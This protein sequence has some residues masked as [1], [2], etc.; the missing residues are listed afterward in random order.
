MARILVVEDD[1]STQ[2]LISA[3]LEKDGHKVVLCADGHEALL[4]VDRERP[5]LLIS[6]INLPGMDGYALVRE[7]RMNPQWLHLPIIYLSSL[8]NRANIR[9][10]MSTG[11]DDYLTKPFSVRELRDA[12]Y[13]QLKK[14]E[15]LRGVQKTAIES[16]IERTKEEISEKYEK[17]LH[18]TVDQMWS[19]AVPQSGWRLINAA[20]LRIGL[21]HNLRYSEALAPEH[22]GDLMHMYL[23]AMLDAVQLF[24]P[25]AVRLANTGLMA[26]YTDGD[27]GTSITKEYRVLKAMNACLTTAT[28]MKH[29][30]GD[31]LHAEGLPAL[32]SCFAMHRGDVIMLGVNSVAKPQPIAVPIGD[33]VNVTQEMYRKMSGQWQI[34]ASNDLAVAMGLTV[35]IGDHQ[36]IEVPPRKE[37]L[38]VCELFIAGRGT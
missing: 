21:R 38:T 23:E 14:H 2:Q 36:V 19:E 15:V 22:L 25:V 8:T 26:V 13:S 7:L 18:E 27:A 32:D 4:M 12:V 28:R 11:A 34:T 20:V 29:V 3:A 10:G 5:D 30:H 6:D 24:D 1:H 33:G 37:S 17:R 31:M 16:A 9:V 35:R